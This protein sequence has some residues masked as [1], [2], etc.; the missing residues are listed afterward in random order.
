MKGYARQES[1]DD[2][3]K[4]AMLGF[5]S[6]SEDAVVD[7]ASKEKSSSSGPPGFE[8]SDMKS[9]DE[10]NTCDGLSYTSSELA[11]IEKNIDAK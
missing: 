7:D 3:A 8:D 9:A 4:I 11:E 6:T 1:E 2:R 5:S 10:Q